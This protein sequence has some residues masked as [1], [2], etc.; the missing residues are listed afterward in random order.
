MNLF[1]KDPKSIE[2]FSLGFIR[3]E[4]EDNMMNQL[5]IKALVELSEATAIWDGYH[6]YSQKLLQMKVKIINN[7]KIKC[8][9]C[10][11]LNITLQ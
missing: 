7:I 1:H 2:D 9:K 5:L 4:S 6:Q 8:K 3:S 10:N 11:E